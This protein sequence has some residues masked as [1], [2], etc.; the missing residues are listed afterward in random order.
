MLAARPSPTGSP[1]P[2]MPPM[3]LGPASPG[4]LEPEPA[5]ERVVHRMTLSPGAGAAPPGPTQPLGRLRPLTTADREDGSGVPRTVVAV[6][7]PSGPICQQ[8]LFSELDRG[9]VT[10][11]PEHRIKAIY[12]SDLGDSVA[13]IMRAPAAVAVAHA[14]ITARALHLLIERSIGTFEY[15]TDEHPT[16]CLAYARS[17]LRRDLKPT[18]SSGKRALAVFISSRRVLRDRVVTVSDVMARAASPETGR[19]LWARTLRTVL[20]YHERKVARIGR[21]YRAPVIKLPSEA[22]IARPDSPLQVPGLDH[23]IERI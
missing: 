13:V 22:L 1:H 20:D 19:E 6:H 23:F 8:A 15:S 18:S 9:L 12:C 3:T 11:T 10:L 7:S 5:A 21:V 14:T 17:G 4:L 2:Q 16:L